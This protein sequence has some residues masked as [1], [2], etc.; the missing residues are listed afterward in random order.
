MTDWKPHDPKYDGHA[1]D[2]W[3]DVEFKSGVSWV[4]TITPSWLTCIEY[5]YRAKQPDLLAQC[6]A[7]P[8]DQRDAL[9][10]ELQKPQRDWADDVWDAAK[11]AYLRN[12][13][14]VTG[15]ASN[16]TAAAVIRSKCLSNH[17]PLLIDIFNCIG[18]IDGAAE[19]R[20]KLLKV[21]RS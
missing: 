6:L 2:D 7:L 14:I 15:R 10:A 21:I 12:N 19:L 8:Q 4:K 13:G 17:D 3:D 20:G 18:G 11:H 5:R 9:I 1:P 16:V